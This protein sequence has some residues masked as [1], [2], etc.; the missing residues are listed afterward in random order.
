MTEELNFHT[1]EFAELEQQLADP[2]I[3][4]DQ[5]RYRTVMQRYSELRPLVGVQDELNAVRRELAEA[6]QLLD[7]PEM[8]D[9]AL[10]EVQELEPREAE[11]ATKLERLLLPRD[12]FDAKDVI[13]E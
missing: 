7:D 1:A 2:D 9:V 12:P 4:A 10:T 5:A 3:L 13:V 6:R 11:L 8:A